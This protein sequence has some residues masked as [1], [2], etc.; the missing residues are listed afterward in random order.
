LFQK[1]VFINNLSIHTLSQADW[2]VYQ[3]YFL[4][5]I[6]RLYLSFTFILIKDEKMKKKILVLLIAIIPT[7]MPNL[8]S[9]VRIEV[10]DDPC[11]WCWLEG[12]AL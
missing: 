6:I 1:I 3:N 10:G 2:S 9:A 11:G 7:L 5:K 12:V 8:A 4:V